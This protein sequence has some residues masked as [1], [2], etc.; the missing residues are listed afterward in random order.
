MCI[1]CANFLN[2][3]EI[4]F[5]KYS[6][7]DTHTAN[8]SKINSDQEMLLISNRKFKY[9]FIYLNGFLKVA[10]LYL[11][12]FKHL[13]VICGFRWVHCEEKNFLMI[14]GGDYLGATEF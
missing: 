2:F 6:R 11:E 9:L 5:A 10:C 4:L 13:D 8:D 7:I 1:C 3:L 14:D 12:F